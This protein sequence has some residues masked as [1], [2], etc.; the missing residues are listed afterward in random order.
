[1]LW[2]TVV[3][4]HIRW[5]DASVGTSLHSLGISFFIQ[6]NV[7]SYCVREKHTQLFP[8]VQ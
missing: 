8:V 2:P 7:G 1:M 3:T 4:V 6:M 5:P